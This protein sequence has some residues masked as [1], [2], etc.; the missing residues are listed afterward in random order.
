MWWFLHIS[1]STFPIS[2]GVAPI[3]ITRAAKGEEEDKDGQVFTSS[4][5]QWTCQDVFWMQKE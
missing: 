4:L 1:L 3:P 2:S 5:T